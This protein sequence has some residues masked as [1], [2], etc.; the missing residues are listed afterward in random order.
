MNGETE[1]KMISIGVGLQN[2]DR[3]QGMIEIGDMRYRS[4]FIWV[5]FGSKL[6][7]CLGCNWHLSDIHRAVAPFLFCASGLARFKTLRKSSV[8][9]RILELIYALLHL[10]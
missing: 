3:N 7:H 6:N 2:P 9:L 4:I 8:F 5:N 10:I 1:E